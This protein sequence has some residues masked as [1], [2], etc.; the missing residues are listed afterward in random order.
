VED[1]AL[2]DLVLIANRKSNRKV[3]TLEQKACDTKLEVFGRTLKQGKWQLPFQSKTYCK[4][5]RY[6]VT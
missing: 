4:V 2:D 6:F 5:D 1:E 3:W